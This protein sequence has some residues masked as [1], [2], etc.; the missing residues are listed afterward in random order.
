MPR[1]GQ[2]WLFSQ[3]FRQNKP[4]DLCRCLVLYTKSK[5]HSLKILCVNKQLFSVQEM[6]Y[7]ERRTCSKI[8]NKVLGIFEN[9][10]N[11]YFCSNLVKCT[12]TVLSEAILTIFFFIL[13]N[14]LLNSVFLIGLS[15]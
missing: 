5:I 12:L 15:L 14:K 3:K 9:F 10:E 2:F 1:K 13:T 4:A 7:R 8:R 11:H 6:S